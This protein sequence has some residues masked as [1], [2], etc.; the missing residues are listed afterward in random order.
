M[1]GSTV[2]AMEGFLVAVVVTVQSVAVSAYMDV[3]LANAVVVYLEP[4]ALISILA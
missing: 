3:A 2:G 1:V 4:P